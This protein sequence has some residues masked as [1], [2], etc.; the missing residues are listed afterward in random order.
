M[1]GG[2]HIIVNF[3]FLNRKCDTGLVCFQ[4]GSHVPVPGCLGGLQDSS[5]TD[6]CVQNPSTTPAPVVAPISPAPTVSPTMS[7]PTAPPLPTTA[8]P[9]VSPQQLV[10]FGGTPPSSRFPLQLCQGM[11]HLSLLKS[12]TLILLTLSF[13]SCRRLRL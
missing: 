1:D 7:G 4:R 2:A 10:S 11:W 9:T 3:Y 5:L 12:S 6:Y 13:V 8:T